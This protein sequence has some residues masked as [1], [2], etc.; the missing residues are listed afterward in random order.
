LLT[1]VVRTLVQH[2]FNYG[3]G[4]DL[5]RH[6]ARTNYNEIE[7][8][9]FGTNEGAWNLYYLQL[10]NIEE[11]IRVAGRDGKT[12]TRAVA[13]ILKAFTAASITDLWGDAPYFN[14]G[15]GGRQTAPAYDSQKDIYTKEGGILDL[16]ET[17]EDLLSN[18][19][20]DLLPQDILYAG[21]RMKWR[22]LGNSL[23]L[24]YLMRISNRATE[25]PGLAEAIRQ[26]AGLP[27][28][29]SNRDNALLPYLAAN[30]NQCPVYVMRA[31]E[32]EYVRMSREMEETLNR[33]NDPRRAVWF[34][35]AA[36][37]P[38]GQ[39]LY[40]GIPS[41]CTSTTLSHIGYSEPDV[42]LLGD[43]FRARPDGCSAVWMNCSEVM[44]LLAEA[45]IKGYV[46]GDAAA[47]YL[48]GISASV[49]YY[50]KSLPDGAYLA[51]P[52][53]AFDS[54]KGLQQIMTQKWLAQFFVG[55]ESWFDYLRTGYP[56]MAP[57][58]DNR[59][60]TRP[61][62][63]PSRFYYPEDEQAL[64]AAHYA[65]AVSHQSGGNDDINTKLWWEK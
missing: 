62:E 41:G 28:M 33:M 9:A 16:L 46:A 5:A 31:G 8:Y 35:P 50:C 7:Q 54:S 39:P 14:A 59:N 22:R 17:A 19:Q 42:S 56:E 52:E 6:V 55:Y 57:L 53:V 47:W 3:N 21:D 61:G 30:P 24:R 44:F 51:Q 58:L 4:A 26:T 36:G 65:E 64:N 63:T 10:N 25:V 40:A 32:F 34:A 27:L 60:P 37:S 45:T 29:E 2:Q 1:P 38:P 18:P 43:Y 15:A 12:S 48:K 20:A 11:M 23:R 49:E 13:C